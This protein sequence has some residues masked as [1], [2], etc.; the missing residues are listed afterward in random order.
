MVLATYFL[1]PGYS[2]SL[3]QVIGSQLD[4]RAIW[5]IAHNLIE[6]LKTV[7]SAGMTYNDLKPGNIMLTDSKITLIDF[8]LCER[9]VEKN[10][11]H[12]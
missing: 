11:R 6:S 8:G 5:N 10:G 3:E 2:L 9:F 1:M 7:H 12:I 4:M